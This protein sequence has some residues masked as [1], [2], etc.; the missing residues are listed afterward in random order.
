MK[1]RHKH[2]R[3][4][5]NTRK[6]KQQ[7]PRLL[8][9]LP[10]FHFPKRIL[11]FI[12]II[13]CSVGLIWWAQTW[14][15]PHDD[16]GGMADTVG[17]NSATTVPAEYNPTT[18]ATGSLRLVAIPDHVVQG[19]PVVFVLAGTT[20]D[21]A[22]NAALSST[23]PVTTGYITLPTTDQSIATTSRASFS[24]A[25]YSKQPI[26]IYG[27][28]INQKTGTSS[29]TVV[30][31]GHEITT[32]VYITRRYRPSEPLPVPDQIGGNSSANQARVA[33]ILDIENAE[34]AA[35]PQGRTAANWQHA[36]GLPLTSTIVITDP[37]GFNR[38]T[39]EISIPH[40]GID[41]K[42]ASGTP[43]YAINDGLVMTA[44]NYTVYGGTVIVNHGLGVQSLY[45]HLSH[46]TATA[47][48]MVKRGQLIGYSGETGYAV[49]PH[50]HLSIKVNGVSIDPKAFF[51][52]FKI[53][54]Y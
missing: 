27:V 16:N 2:H 45:M 43:V 3:K 28:G 53:L 39:G 18:L 21:K 7:E 19:E 6:Q 17:G 4:H 10:S 38:E 48:T 33:S 44:K 26:A 32:P 20:T 37:Y 46:I 51:N 22:V 36:F 52:I 25:R 29:M 41:F 34:I 13:I 14:D 40:K 35:L 47:G 50:L 49:G 31:A 1:H 30:L 8:P 24:F 54:G 9:T 11:G 5:K 15:I 23:N 42:A 12:A